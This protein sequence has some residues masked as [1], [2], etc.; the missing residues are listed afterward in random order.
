MFLLSFHAIYKEVFLLN[1]PTS[2]GVAPTLKILRCLYNVK[3]RE[4]PPFY[5]NRINIPISSYT[6]ARL[7]PHKQHRYILLCPYNLSQVLP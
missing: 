1:L 7:S 6:T 2:S 3:R 4:S 5:N